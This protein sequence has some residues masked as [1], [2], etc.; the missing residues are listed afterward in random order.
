MRV[1][2]GTARGSL[3]QAP[4]GLETRPT[5][6][7]MKESLFN[8][9]APDLQDCYFLDLFCGSGAIGIEALSRGAG[10]AVFV[11]SSKACVDITSKNLI[12][13]KLEKR[14]TVLGQ[15]FEKALDRLHQKNRCFDIVFMDPPYGRGYIEKTL[16]RM[17]E[18]NILKKDGYIV[19]EL[20][21]NEKLL[22]TAGFQIVKVKQYRTTAFYF[23][24]Q[25][26]TS[27]EKH[28]RHISGEF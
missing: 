13:T 19:A 16:L 20:S 1:I 12:K 6:D 23:L 3:L 8:M 15:S 28:D 18:I 7:R 14:G 5:A 24:N 11:D 25:T 26:I 10:F 9:L 4:D 27:E 17:T 2:S 22:D 21:S